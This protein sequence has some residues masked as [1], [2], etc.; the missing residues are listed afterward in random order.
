MAA[1]NGIPNGG[2]PYSPESTAGAMRQYRAVPFDNPDVEANAK[3]NGRIM[4]DG[5]RCTRAWTLCVCDPVCYVLAQLFTPIL[6]TCYGHNS[7]KVQMRDICAVVSI[8]P[9]P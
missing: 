2:S 5:E 4:F 9:T 6:C 1:A 3:A 8:T 7:P